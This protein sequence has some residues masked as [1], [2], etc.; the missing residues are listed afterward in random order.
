MAVS[1][2]LEFLGKQF[3]PAFA[4]L[5]MIRADQAEM[6]DDIRV[7]TAI[8]LRHENTLKDML[9]HVRAMVAQR[10]RFNDRLRR[11]EEQPAQ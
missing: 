9:A 11:L 6:R 3:E 1:V 8:V 2:T 4:E 5:R 7:L 10:Q